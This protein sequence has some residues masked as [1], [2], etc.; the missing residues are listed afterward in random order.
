[1]SDTDSPLRKGVQKLSS[2]SSFKPSNRYLVSLENVQ[3]P[4]KR[5]RKTAD[6]V[7][8]EHLNHSLNVSTNPSNNMESYSKG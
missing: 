5:T 2:N 1:M 6:K 3:L 7:T 4:A 8:I